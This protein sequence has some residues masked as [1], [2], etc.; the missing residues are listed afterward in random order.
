MQ[1]RH[2]LVIDDNPN[3]L[4][5]LAELLSMVGIGS[6]LV[7]DVTQL[8]DAL[9]ALP[10][11]DVVFL[12]LEMPQADGYEVL[13]VLRHEVG[14]DV[15]IVACTVHLNEIHTAREQGFHSFLGKP[16]HPK[17]FPDQMRRIL[18]GE[19]VWEAR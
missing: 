9:A 6:T 7:Q 5:V 15:P 14:V 8:N 2:A 19:H 11:L 16:L 10:Q 12:D 3:N 13:D 18:D 1:D 4:E 17:R